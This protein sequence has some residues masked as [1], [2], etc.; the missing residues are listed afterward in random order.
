MTRINKIKPTTQPTLEQVKTA[1]LAD[2]DTWTKTAIT[3]GFFSEAMGSRNKYDSDEVDQ[4]NLML[5]RQV[6]TSPDFATNPTYQGKIPLRAIPEGQTE[7]VIFMHNATQVQKVV[8]DLA[9]HIGTCK[10]KGWV[11]QEA[12]GIAATTEA[13]NV[14][15]WS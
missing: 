6:S 15:V 8:D 2:I 9:L 1:K 10:Q 11:L 12:V 7:K 14:I 5:M 13:V 4:Q 3:G